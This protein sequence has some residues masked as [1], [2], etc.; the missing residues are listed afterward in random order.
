MI[1]VIDTFI[2]F[3]EGFEDKLDIS[4][5]DKIKLWEQIYEN[6]YPIILHKCK[7]D[8]GDEGYKWKDIAKDMVFNRTKDDFEKMLEAHHNINIMMDNINDKVRDSFDL[9]LDIN[10][11]L[12]A[13][14]CNSAGWVDEYDGKMA[15]LYGIDQIAKLDWHTHD[16]IEP[17][18]AHELMHVIHF[19]IRNKNNI[20]DKHETMYEEG[21]WRVYI[22]GFAQFYQT[23]L[24]SEEKESRGI[25]WIRACDD[26]IRKIK[27]LYLQALNDKEKG[28]ND[29]FGDWYKVIGISDTGYY[30]GQEFIRY[31]SRK[32]SFYEIGTLE[33]EVIE[34]E[35]LTFLEK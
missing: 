31:L 24:M 3:K 12:Y 34:R 25:E 8:F 23:K 26:N 15:I 16:K 7:K 13:G 18:L 5:K 10:I 27:K 35:F 21:L 4:V 2:N 22:E 1:N 14:L 20:N 6:S 33:F 9:D 30:L 17:L 28:T 29:F 19:Y 32:Y 11:V